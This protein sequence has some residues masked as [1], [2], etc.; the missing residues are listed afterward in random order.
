MMSPCS[1]VLFSNFE[2]NF[3]KAVVKGE[4]CGAR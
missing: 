3:D 4:A 2:M 1:S